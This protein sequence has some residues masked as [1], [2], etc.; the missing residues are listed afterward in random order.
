MKMTPALKTIIVLVQLFAI[1]WLAAQIRNPYFDSPRVDWEPLHILILF[2]TALVIPTAAGLIVASTKNKLLPGLCA[3]LAVLSGPMWMLAMLI[4]A[5]SAS[6]YEKSSA[7][8]FVNH[9]S[10]SINSFWYVLH[11]CEKPYRSGL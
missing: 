3:A 6:T 9:S 2:I 1:L 10:V 11:V 5:V 8:G 7:N 4:A